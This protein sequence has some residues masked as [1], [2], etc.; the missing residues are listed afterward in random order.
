LIVAALAGAL[1]LSCG[2]EG[3]EEEP[4]VSIV[5]LR[6]AVERNPEDVAALVALGRALMDREGA[7]LEAKEVLERAL[8]L[9]P[10]DA[11]VHRALGR[12]FMLVGLY[13]KAEEHL[14]KALELVRSTTTWPRPTH[15]KPSPS[16]RRCA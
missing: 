11:R 16:S 5:E 13:P 3:K 1:V 2:K 14:L 7:Y 6:D 9:S 12:L 8:S 10:E 4:K 15:G